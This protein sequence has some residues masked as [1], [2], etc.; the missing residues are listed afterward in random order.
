LEPP[1]EDQRRLFEDASHP[2]C[3]ISNSLSDSAERG[4]IRLRNLLLESSTLSFLSA[5]FTYVFI[6]S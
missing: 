5:C 4:T 3:F 6:H 1:F 2:L